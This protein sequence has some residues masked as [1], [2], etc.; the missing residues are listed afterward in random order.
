[1]VAA[2]VASAGSSPASRIRADEEVLFLPTCGSQADD[3]RAWRLP[4]HAWVFEY[5]EESLWRS[6]MVGKLL[7]VLE[8]GTSVADLARFRQRAWAFMVDSERDK[9][10]RVWVAGRAYRL[11]ATGADGHARGEV[12]VTREGVRER[13][14]EG[15]LE[16]AAGLAAGDEPRF[17]G[18]I[19]L[20]PPRG[21]S[22]VSDIDDTI[23][24]SEVLDRKQLVA[25][26][27][28]REH[29]AV[30]GMA[31]LYARWASAGAVF[32]YLS[33]SPWQLYPL[34]SEFLEL[35][36]FPAGS[37]HL[38]QLRVKDSSFLDLFASPVAHK[39]EA[40]EQLLATYP[41]RR[42]VLVGDSAEQD[43][44]LYAAIARDHPGQVMHVLIREVTGDERRVEEITGLLA[45]QPVPHTLFR[46]A[47][48]LGTGI[49]IV[50]GGAAGTSGPD[51][52][53]SNR[54]P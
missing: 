23:K 52:S 39:T 46:D 32:H 54:A 38:R 24:V 28:L 9:V 27:F 41:E 42:F 17:A 30:P 53:G 35:E 45:G 37:W 26:T 13:E 14:A 19:W 44:E 34:L 36:G 31:P 11:A 4:V 21:V 29:R 5:E 7:Q 43:P 33:A 10:V 51:P 12:L 25:N 48:E 50:V 8:L 18:R 40:L 22:V 6:A 3:G 2:A 20:V 49:D 15:W 47:S 1:M 16:V